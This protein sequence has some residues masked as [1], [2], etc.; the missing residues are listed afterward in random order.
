[1]K[2]RK[3]FAKSWKS[4]IGWGPFKDQKLI[5]W[6]E[7]DGDEDIIAVVDIEE[8]IDSDKVHDCHVCLGYGTKGKH[9]IGVHTEKGGFLEKPSSI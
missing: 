7:D 5:V 1:M 9:I 4:C 6:T 8:A 2:L 3:S